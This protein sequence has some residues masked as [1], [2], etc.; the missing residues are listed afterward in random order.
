ML[1]VNICITA[2]QLSGLLSEDGQVSIREILDKGANFVLREVHDSTAM[3]I[4]V[5]AMIYVV[6]R[7]A[8]VCTRKVL[9]LIPNN[10][11][12]KKGVNRLPK[13]TRFTMDT[14]LDSFISIRAMFSAAAHR[15]TL[16]LCTW[17]A[18]CH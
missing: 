9:Q 13:T 3:A 16:P 2:L 4:R 18:D 17:Q 8:I 11:Y 12:L 10:R 1:L 14:T 7:A 15:K 6:F 5:S